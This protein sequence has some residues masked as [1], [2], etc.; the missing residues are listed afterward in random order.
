MIMMMAILSV[1]QE[2][3]VNDALEGEHVALLEERERFY[4]CVDDTEIPRAAQYRTSFP[5]Q[6]ENLHAKNAAS[7][8]DAHLKRVAFLVSCVQCPIDDPRISR[9]HPTHM[10]GGGSGGAPGNIT[11]DGTSVIDVELLPDP[12]TVPAA[13]TQRCILTSLEGFINSMEQLP[14]SRTSSHV[15]QYRDRHF[16]WYANS[17]HVHAMLESLFAVIDNSPSLFSHDTSPLLRAIHLCYVKSME[18]VA[19]CDVS[20]FFRAFF[21]GTA[22]GDEYSYLHGYGRPG[23]F[24]SYIA[25]ISAVF[26]GHDRSGH[27]RITRTYVHSCG[28]CGRNKRVITTGPAI[29][30]LC[31]AR[32]HYTPQEAIDANVTYCRNNS[33]VYCDSCHRRMPRTQETRSTPSVLCFDA[34]AGDSSTMALPLVL[35]YTGSDAVFDL[36]SVVYG[37][38]SHFWGIHK[39]LTSD[40]PGLTWVHVDDMLPSSTPRREFT[41]HSRKDPSQSRYCHALIYTRRRVTPSVITPPLTL[42][43]GSSQ[44]GCCPTSHFSSSFSSNRNLLLSLRSSLAYV[45]HLLLT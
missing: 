32:L 45:V 38:D 36:V 14:L 25:E 21:N 11:D 37:D 6:N 10:T 33:P 28:C 16:A 43:H 7:T 12:T 9:Y 26:E 19:L 17:C 5:L 39:R 29:I 8:L 13:F 2:D 22:D 42:V 27:F 23:L 15:T 35:H 41:V 20:D 34:G 4:D 44:L 18:G 40:G 1:L 30:S 3:E 24:G 31:D